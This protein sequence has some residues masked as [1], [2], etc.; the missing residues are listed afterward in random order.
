MWAFKLLDLTQN[1]LSIPLG[2]E[3]T[4]NFQFPMGL[5]ENTCTTP[6]VFSNKL[7]VAILQSKVI[8]NEAG[9]TYQCITSLIH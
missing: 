1:T 6:S 3:A 9:K 2:L 7:I 8:S 5:H 4:D